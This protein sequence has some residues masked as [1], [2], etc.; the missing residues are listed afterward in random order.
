MSEPVRGLIVAHASLATAMVSTVRRICGDLKGA[1]QPLSNE[2]RGPEAL[3]A[4][5]E[6]AAGDGAVLL[7]TDLGAGSCAMTARRMCR[8]RPGTA[9]VCGFNVPMMVDFVFNRERPLDELVERMVERGRAG[10]T[11]TYC[12]TEDDVR[13]SSSN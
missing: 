4:A 5:V 12:K 2:G 1:L 8:D 10:I 9:M 7:F 6:E 3:H 11:G 13:R